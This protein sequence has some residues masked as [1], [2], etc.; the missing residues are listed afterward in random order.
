MEVKTLNSLIG[1]LQDPYSTQSSL[2]PLLVR[3][4]HTIY[5]HLM[6]PTPILTRKR[7]LGSFYR[8]VSLFSLNEYFYRLWTH[9]SENAVGQNVSFI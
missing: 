2:L 9:R 8:F 6:N 5:E 4:K 7:R 3:T 1:L